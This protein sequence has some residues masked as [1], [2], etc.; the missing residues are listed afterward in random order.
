M[1]VSLAAHRRLS[2][3]QPLSTA[4]RN[5][6]QAVHRAADAI[7]RL[8]ENPVNRPDTLKGVEYLELQRRRLRNIAESI[9]TAFQTRD[10]R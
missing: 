5:T 2:S 6:V 10:F 3:R 7:T 9:D 1:A 4:E 8:V